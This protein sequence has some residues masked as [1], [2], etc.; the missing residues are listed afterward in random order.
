MGKKGI[1]TV[2]WLTNG[3]L[4][5][6]VI[7]FSLMIMYMEKGVS[8]SNRL[9]FSK[10]VPLCLWGAKTVPLGVP[11]I[12]KQIGPLGLLFGTLFSECDRR[13]K[14]IPKMVIRQMCQNM[15]LGA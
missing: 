13:H 5:Q 11:N 12:N 9:P 3:T 2:P 10:R 15:Q 4:F 1:K 14:E 6:K 8:L 7:L